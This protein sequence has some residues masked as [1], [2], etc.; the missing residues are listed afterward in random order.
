MIF[1]NHIF[2]IL[3]HAGI[4]LTKLALMATK[5]FRLFYLILAAAAVLTAVI[6]YLSPKINLLPEDPYAIVDLVETD[7]YAIRARAAEITKGNTT[8]EGAAYALFKHV[9]EHETT[10][11]MLITLASYF[12]NSEIPV[13]FVFTE[14]RTYLL[15]CGLSKS[16]LFGE[17][18]NDLEP[19]YTDSVR[20]G[21][22]QVWIKAPELTSGSNL[23]VTLEATQPVDIYMLESPRE[24]DFS[25][26]LGSL[27]GQREVRHSFPIKPGNALAVVTSAAT[28][29]DIKLALSSITEE[30]MAVTYFRNRECLPFDPVRGKSW[31]TSYEMLAENKLHVSQ[32]K[33]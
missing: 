12:E 21:N 26:H 3:L 28:K 25:K 22:G 18:I 11:D 2:E 30:N 9:T 16:A 7:D 23:M 24:V 32:P 29:V 10:D 27:R 1:V 17:I 6:V 19:I 20:L 4:I 13:Q 31:L 15:G 33:H 14:D 8:R 5:V